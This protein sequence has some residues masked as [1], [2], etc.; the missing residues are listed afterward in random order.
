[1]D[2]GDDNELANE[3]AAADTICLFCTLAAAE[4]IS[5]GALSPSRISDRV[6][7]SVF[8]LTAW[9]IPAESPPPIA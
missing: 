6:E 3:V 2:G 4:I 9:P 1:V 5:M 7:T 8:A